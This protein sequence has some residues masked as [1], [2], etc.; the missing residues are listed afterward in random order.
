MCMQALSLKHSLKKSCLV[1]AIP[2]PIC[3]NFCG[4]MRLVSPDSERQ[5]NVSNIL[6]YPVIK[7]LRFGFVRLL[8]SR[9]F[10][11]HCANFGRGDSPLSFKLG[12]PLSHVGP[13]LEGGK[14]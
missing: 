14:H 10:I 9:N 12:I 3:E 8:T 1:L 7:S 2:I 6:R 4:S 5:T 11:G 13:T